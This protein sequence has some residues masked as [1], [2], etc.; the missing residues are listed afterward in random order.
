MKAQTAARLGCPPGIIGRNHTGI[1][2][3]VLPTE[4]LIPRASRGSGETQSPC[5]FTGDVSRLL[6]PGRS[7]HRLKSAAGRQAATGDQH[8]HIC[9]SS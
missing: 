9:T 8:Q 7:P 6:A 4:R 2:P 1:I 3:R 5:G